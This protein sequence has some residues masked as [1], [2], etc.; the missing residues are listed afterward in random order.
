MGSG[1]FWSQGQYKLCIL[2]LCDP[3][4]GGKWEGGVIVKAILPF[5]IQTSISNSAQS[6]K[7]GFRSPGY[8]QA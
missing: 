3:D 5:L 8:V 1:D 2:G 6:A 4:W 7:I